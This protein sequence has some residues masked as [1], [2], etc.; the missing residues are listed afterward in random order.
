ML[1]GALRARVLFGVLAL[2]LAAGPAAAERFAT[3][4]RAAE[5]PI[6]GVESRPAIGYERGRKLAIRVVTIGWAEVEVRTARAFVAMALAAR[7]AGIEL[8]IR[9]GYRPPEHQQWLYDAWRRG[10]G[11]PAARPGFSTHQSGRALDLDIQTPG[12][13]DWLETHAKK[14]GFA[15]TVRGEPWHWELVKKVKRRA[16]SRRASPRS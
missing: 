11:N 10:W 8:W 4:P 14:F 16:S 1:G 2:A 12:T 15:R 3:P 5:D 13:F 7:D 9:S 6:A